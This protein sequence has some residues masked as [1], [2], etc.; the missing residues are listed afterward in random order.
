M[1]EW[2]FPWGG[3]TKLYRVTLEEDRVDMSGGALGPVLSLTPS[4]YRAG[5][6]S[7]FQ[8][9]HGEIWAI[10]A[11]V[12]APGAT[13][14]PL[15]TS[16]LQPI[17]A[18]QNAIHVRLSRE[19]IEQITSVQPVNSA[20]LLRI[21]LSLLVAAEAAKG[22]SSMIGEPKDVQVPVTR[23][24]EQLLPKIG[25]P[26]RRMVPLDMS[27]PDKVGTA[28][29]LASTSWSR[30]VQR[31]T[32]ALEK[33]YYSHD[34]SEAVA[35]VRFAIEGAVATWAY[36]WGCSVAPEELN[37]GLA[38]GFLEERAGMK[39]AQKV[40]GSAARRRIWSRLST[41]KTL[42][43]VAS[44]GHH[45]GRKSIATRDDADGLVTASVGMLRLLPEFL[46]AFPE[47]PND[48]S[49]TNAMS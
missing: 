42:H 1:T 11:D 41:L 15:F 32:A 10:S 18:N 9:L 3:S 44:D 40:K 49:S 36:A 28:N 2:E 38:L 14:P 26:K 6:H 39:V 30:T 13:Y 27:V 34:P 7:P 29:S 8:S 23:W 4:L 22:T 24:H 16:G 35:E 21:R 33:F 37:F 12:Y 47:P 25:F 5:D 17:A 20:I 19:Y 31:L 46:D 43:D 45:I 48:D